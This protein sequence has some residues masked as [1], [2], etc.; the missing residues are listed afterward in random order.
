MK[1]R[2]RGVLDTP[3]ARGMT[4][5]CAIPDLIAFMTRKSGLIFPAGTHHHGRDQMVALA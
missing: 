5:L 3:H 1:L 4:T 2:S